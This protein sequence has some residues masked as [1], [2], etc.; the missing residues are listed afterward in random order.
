MIINIDFD[1]TI[2]EH[3]YPDIGNGVLSGEPYVKGKDYGN[4]QYG[5]M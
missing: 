2:V 3:R 5:I 1:G 4:Q